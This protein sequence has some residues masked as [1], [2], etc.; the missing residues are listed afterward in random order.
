MGRT[1][2]CSRLSSVIAEKNYLL[3][4]SGV[5]A[6]SHIRNVLNMIKFQRA[7]ELGCERA[8][9]MWEVFRI[10]L[11]HPIAEILCILNCTSYS[12]QNPCCMWLAC[13]K[14]GKSTVPSTNFWVLKGVIG[15]WQSLLGLLCLCWA[16]EIDRR[17]LLKQ[18]CVC[19]L[20]NSANQVI[21]RTW[22]NERFAEHRGFQTIASTNVKRSLVD[23]QENRV[24]SRRGR[25]H[26][27]ILWLLLG[28]VLIMKPQH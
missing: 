11:G 19:Y 22:T 28:W 7:N 26:F 13:V 10:D 24:F 18:F 9:K 2:E 6:M 23:T 17:L 3:N 15:R 5:S 16:F 27:S 14:S 20:R 25:L 1:W 8:V 12:I 21:K 4:A